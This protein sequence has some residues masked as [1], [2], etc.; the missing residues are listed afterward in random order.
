MF[1]N[2]EISIK[3]LRKYLS[4]KND[5]CKWRLELKFQHLHNKP[6]IMGTPLM[7]MLRQEDN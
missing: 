4:S 1:N 2:I 7:G 3:K 6:G 5:L